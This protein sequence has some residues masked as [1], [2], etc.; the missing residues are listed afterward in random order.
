MVAFIVAL[1]VAAQVVFAPSAAAQPASKGGPSQIALIEQATRLLLQRYFEPIDSSAIFNAGIN[2]ANTEL[3]RQSVNV[4]LRQTAFSRDFNTD[5]QRFA[6]S[7][8]G[9][10]D[11]Y[12]AQIDQQALAYATISAM[13]ESLNDC[14]TY[15]MPASIAQ[16][17]QSGLR[18]SGGA[19][20]IGA[21]LRSGPDGYPLVEDIFKG[22]PADKAGVGRGDRMLSVDDIDLKGVRLETIQA[23]LREPDGQP[24][25]LMFSRASVPVPFPVKIVRG[26]YKVPVWETEILPGNVGYLRI[27]VFAET[28][29]AA[30]VQQMYRDLAT[31]GAQSVMVDLRNNPGGSGQ[32]AIAL[33]SA[34]LQPSQLLFA[35]AN[36]DGSYLPFYS[37]MNLWPTRPSL[38]ILV[39]GRSASASEIVAAVAQD[40]QVGRVFG[41]KTKGCLASV[42][43]T[44]LSDG[45]ALGITGAKVVTA[46]QRSLNRIGVTPDAVIETTVNDLQR[47]EDPQLQ[48]AADWL[49]Y[50]R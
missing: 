24:V 36:R 8:A 25:Q 17:L 47:G 49:R 34:W 3:Q 9:A 21:V 23:K 31:K 46:Q 26:E 18:G 4:T 22:S 16:Q 40:Y 5:W 41:S 15:F 19:H 2:G 45:S 6:Q 27:H 50:K 30:A 38:A 43:F 20:G 11:A 28:I 33:M 48:R 44:P 14:H 35:H 37:Q 12:A 1:V 32:A 7:Y 10:A 42:E 39:N 13:A 29:D